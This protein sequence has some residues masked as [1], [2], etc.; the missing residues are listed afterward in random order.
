MFNRKTEKRL[1]NNTIKDF[2]NKNGL[3]PDGIIGPKTLCSLEK[4]RFKKHL[5]I[6][7][8][9][10]PVVLQISDIQDITDIEYFRDRLFRALL[11]PVR[12]FENE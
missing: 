5:L 10:K 8:I 3:V 6:E 11:L 2:Q 7:K 4:N 1:L 12:F 9:P